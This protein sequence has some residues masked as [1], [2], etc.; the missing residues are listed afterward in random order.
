MNQNYPLKKQTRK[1]QKCIAKNELYN[2][3]FYYNQQLPNES[4]W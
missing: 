3:L 1:S 2:N 4:R